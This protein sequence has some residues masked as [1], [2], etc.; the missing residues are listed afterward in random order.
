M[1]WRQRRQGSATTRVSMPP[2]PVDAALSANKNAANACAT[3]PSTL[4]FVF[5]AFRAPFCDRPLERSPGPA[6]TVPRATFG[7]AAGQREWAANLLVAH[8]AHSRTHSQ[9]RAP[10]PN[11]PVARPAPD[12]PLWPHVVKV[13]DA[14]RACSSAHGVSLGAGA[15]WLEVGYGWATDVAARAFYGTYNKTKRQD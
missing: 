9:P 6:P 11:Q 12:R 4:P 8:I 1:R 13:T 3:P 15:V 14:L 2:P 5:L 10:L 7:G